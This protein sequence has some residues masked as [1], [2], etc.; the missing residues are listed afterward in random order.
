[1]GIHVN[2]P[3]QDFSLL[4][5]RP[6][7]A[8]T[9]QH[10]LPLK[11]QFLETESRALKEERKGQLL[12]NGMEFLFGVMEKNLKINSDDSCTTVLCT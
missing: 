4:Y 5:E 7:T 12:R 11:K 8:F 6:G 3:E 2:F 1:M 10:L 9:D